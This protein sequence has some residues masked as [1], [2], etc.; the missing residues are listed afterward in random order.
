MERDDASKGGR[1][2]VG[3]GLSMLRGFSKEKNGQYHF[4]V[5]LITML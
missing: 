4:S 2:S 5:E 3:G 1:N